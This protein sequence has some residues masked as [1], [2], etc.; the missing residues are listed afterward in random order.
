[1]DC[2]AIEETPDKLI[3]DFLN[4]CEIKCNDLDSIVGIIIPREQLLNISLY[5]IIPANKYVI[6]INGMII[7]KL[8]ISK[9]I[10]KKFMR[11]TLL[12]IE[13]R[14]NLF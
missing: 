11:Y 2:S 10:G 14:L 13:I 3:L 8:N 1:M 4:K 6:K 12:G 7:I 5:D 9:V